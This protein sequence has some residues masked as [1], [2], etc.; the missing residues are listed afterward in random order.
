MKSIIFAL[1]LIL[2]TQAFASSKVLDCSLEG[3]G[4]I[5]NVLVTQENGKFTLTERDNEGHMHVREISRTE[6]TSGRITLTTLSS[7]TK[8]GL[9]HTADGWSFAFVSP[10]WKDFG[11]ANCR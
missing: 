7:D 2:S 8:G 9:S 4:D 5:T 3:G 11:M 1:S 10:S 6:L